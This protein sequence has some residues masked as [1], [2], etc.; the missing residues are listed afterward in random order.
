MPINVNFL[1]A[2]SDTNKLKEQ[3]E[4]REAALDALIKAKSNK[5][6]VLAA[7]TAHQLFWNGIEPDLVSDK[8]TLDKSDLAKIR[9]KAAEQRIILGLNNANVEVLVAILTHNGDDCREY[10]ALQ[11]MLPLNI[12]VIDESARDMKSKYGA[13]FWK[14]LTGVLTNDILLAIRT[15]ATQQLL[16]LAE[17][18]L[19]Q[20]SD[21]AQLS[22]LKKL[23]DANNV[24]GMINTLFGIDFTAELSNTLPA[25]FKE[26]LEKKTAVAVTALSTGK[27]NE[28]EHTEIS[29][30]LNTSLQEDIAISTDPAQP[31]INNI[32]SSDEYEN[33]RD[34]DK[35]INA[36]ILVENSVLDTSSATEVD[37]YKK[38]H[39]VALAQFIADNTELALKTDGVAS[40]NKVLHAMPDFSSP[41]GCKQ[42]VDAISPAFT[43]NVDQ[44]LYSLLGLSADGQ[45]LSDN[46]LR[47]AIRQQHQ[48]NV[49]IID[50]SKVYN[51]KG[52]SISYT[53]LFDLFL[54]IEKKTSLVTNNLSFDGSE[55]ERYF[56]LIKNGSGPTDFLSKCPATSNDEQQLKKEL[57][58]HLTVDLFN[59]L[60]KEIRSAPL[61]KRHDE[62]RIALKEIDEE[63][64]QLAKSY[65]PLIKSLSALDYLVD[66][67]PEQLA[68]PT[69][70]AK[71]SMDA[72]ALRAKY[73][74]LAEQCL[75]VAQ[76]LTHDYEQLNLHFSSIPL[77]TQVA[78]INPL[79]K[80]LG[81]DNLKKI[82]AY[83][84]S[85]PVETAKIDTALNQYQKLNQKMMDIIDVL[86]HAAEGGVY[87]KVR[88]GVTCR[89]VPHAEVNKNLPSQVNE[90]S[91]ANVRLEMNSPPARENWQLLKTSEHESAF[92]F[93]TEHNNPAKQVQIRGRFSQTYPQDVLAA[94]VSIAE[95]EKKPPVCRI[96]ANQVPTFTK[97]LQGGDKAE[98]EHARVK[99]F[100]E[101]AVAL[102]AANHGKAPTK[103][104]PIRL[105]GSDPN[106]IKYLWTALV[107][108][109]EGKPAFGKEAISVHASSF[110]PKDEEGRFLGYSNSSLYNTVFKKY[111]TDVVAV[112]DN[113]QQ[114]LADDGHEKAA[115]VMEQ[116]KSGLERA[117]F[118]PKAVNKLVAEEGPAPEP[119]GMHK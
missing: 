54:S 98:L 112:R 42:F 73:A 90:V 27:I 60:Q 18:K 57:A 89:A 117:K 31:L 56:T 101:M 108:L 102:L 33:S 111:K 81:Q 23:L 84:K 61:L 72:E 53:K 78:K 30:A 37:H 1:A 99:F 93:D 58:S 16:V 35:T 43:H 94:P 109:G 91:G 26:S 79:D 4:G 97:P 82:Q 12:T 40:I 34:V 41:A 119:R 39:N 105:Y 62:A 69:F 17:D 92:I 67:E 106:E 48:F 100:M 13:E 59:A 87:R 10:I 66:V 95:G 21:S 20:I 14:K 47:E 115:K 65:E 49:G 118:D 45:S 80:K 70:Q 116:F 76:Q 46:P 9:Q 32:V 38:I 36:E 6:E 114:A 19:G 110:N 85:I 52:S 28:T 103:D 8:A 63:L 86:N 96:E 2:L 74:A 51:K 5:T 7:I 29:N 15:A 22:P 107:L 68:G 24:R 25:A 44:R 83:E 71:A 77:A 88:D 64:K 50:L 104:N 113:S 3:T 75:T 55:L 11:K